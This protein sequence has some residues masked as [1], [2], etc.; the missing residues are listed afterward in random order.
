MSHKGVN[1]DLRSKHGFIS[2]LIT[3]LAGVLATVGWAGTDH[4]VCDPPV[5]VVVAGWDDA[6]VHGAQHWRQVVAVDACDPPAAH[7][8]GVTSTHFWVIL[9][10]HIR[11]LHV[12]VE[13]GRR[14]Q[15]DS[16]TRNHCIIHQS[17]HPHNGLSTHNHWCAAYL[18]IVVY[19]EFITLISMMS[20]LNVL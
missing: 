8:A 2:A 1:Q 7:S 5:V 11:R 4:I 3:H 20:L 16:N 19:W 15:L 6:D 10:R 17:L 9:C 13:L 18:A 12:D 14:A